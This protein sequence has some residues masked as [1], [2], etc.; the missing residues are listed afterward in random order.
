MGALSHPP[1]P[2]ESTTTDNTLNPTTPLGIC[3]HWTAWA[4]HYS[5]K[6]AH[7]Q[8]QCAGICLHG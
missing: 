8:E 7:T 4:C 6:F 5:E 2:S 3:S 1:Y